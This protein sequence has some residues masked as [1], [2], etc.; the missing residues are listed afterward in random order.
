M[1]LRAK[2]DARRVPDVLMH[3]IVAVARR[4]PGNDVLEL[5]VVG[6]RG[7]RTFTLNSTVDAWD[8]ALRTELEHLLGG[9]VEL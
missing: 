1:L 7:A 8:P 6:R 2:V 4:H 3:D 5:V 9:E